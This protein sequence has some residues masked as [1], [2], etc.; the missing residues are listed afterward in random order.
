MLWYQSQIYMCVQHK[1]SVL[2]TIYLQ[3]CIVVSLPMYQPLTTKLQQSAM[4]CY[5]L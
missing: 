1:Q 5:T 4:V 3:T 2:C